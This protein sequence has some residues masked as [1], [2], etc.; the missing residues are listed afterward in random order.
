MR[1]S[2]PPL[3]ARKAA[4]SVLPVMKVLVIAISSPHSPR[5]QSAVQILAPDTHVFSELDVRNFAL[6]E[7]LSP[8]GFALSTEVHEVSY[9][10]KFFFQ[11]RRHSQILSGLLRPN[12]NSRA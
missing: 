9:G 10:E 3:V 5:F 1:L 11:N 2:L 7:A 4:N 6:G 8:T 12:L